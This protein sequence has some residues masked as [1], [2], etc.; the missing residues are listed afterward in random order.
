MEKHIPVLLNEVIEG[1]DIKKDGTYVDLTLGR[2]GHSSKIVEKLDNGCL[3]GVDQDETAIRES[4]ERLAR[5]ENKVRI[6]R[7]NFRKIKEIL[8]QLNIDKVDG[9]LMDLGVSSPQLDVAERGFSYHYD[10]PLDMR[11]DQSRNLTAYDIVNSYDI[12][13]LT[14][15]LRD[16]GDE[17]YAY[18]ISKNIIKARQ[19]KPIETTFEVVDIIKASKPMRELAKVGHPAKQTF[20]ALRIETNDELNALKDALNDSLESLKS[21]GRLA[22]ITFHSGE[23]RIVKTLFN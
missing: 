20:Q 13:E 1:L 23:D 7:S 14:R 9:I 3:I 18:Q 19:N 10:G 22:V 21:G 15:V 5:Y 17:K 2:A 11:M 12:K 4:S 16:Y 6:V 8:N